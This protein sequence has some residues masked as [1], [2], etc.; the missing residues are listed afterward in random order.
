[1]L[2]NI[3]RL[4]FEHRVSKRITIISI[5]V[6]KLEGYYRALSLAMSIGGTATGMS[7]KLVRMVRR[8]LVSEDGFEQCLCSASCVCVL[9]L[10]VC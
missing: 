2:N 4:Y 10:A 5:L 3:V 9:S 1:M 6:A 8:E 7:F